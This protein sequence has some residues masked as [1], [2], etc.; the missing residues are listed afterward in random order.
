CITLVPISF[1]SP[2]PYRLM[3]EDTATSERA[4]LRVVPNP[5]GAMV[6]AS[7]NL[8][9][10]YQKAESL[11]IYTMLGTLVTELDLKANSGD[12]PLDISRFPSGTYIISLQ[13]D[14]N[15]ILHQKLVKK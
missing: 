14:G 2:S 3:Q 9:T 11:K 10:E 4:F 1:T 12:I 7:Y 6:A 15:T 13:A 5:A 8:G